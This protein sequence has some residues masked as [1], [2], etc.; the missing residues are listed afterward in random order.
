MII[1]FVFQIVC[2]ACFEKYLSEVFQNGGGGGSGTAPT[3]LGPMER[4]KENKE[5]DEE[6]KILIGAP[7]T[8]NLVVYDGQ[9]S[10]RI[11]KISS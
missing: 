5:K 10:S 6:H 3:T 11:I 9:F 1:K 4:E 2:P 8:K 7:A